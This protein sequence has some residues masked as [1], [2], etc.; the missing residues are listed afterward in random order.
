MDICDL[1]NSERPAE[2]KSDFPDLEV[3]T[4]E[5]CAVSGN[6][7]RCCG[8]Y[9]NT[10]LEETTAFRVYGS[11]SRLSGE[12]AKDSNSH[13]AQPRKALTKTEHKCGENRADPPNCRKIKDDYLFS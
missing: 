7:E 11:G 5:S 3:F 12:A 1:D 9:T 4:S 6:H 2:R 10:G 8:D 13:P